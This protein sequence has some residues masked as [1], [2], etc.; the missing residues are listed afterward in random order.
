MRSSCPGEWAT[1]RHER[2][3]GED[4]RERQRLLVRIR[5]LFKAMDTSNYVET[6]D[7]QLAELEQIEA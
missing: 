4:V 2:G 3:Q 5:E 1:V 6:V 7:E